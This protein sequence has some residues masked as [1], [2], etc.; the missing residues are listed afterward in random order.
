MAKRFL[1]LVWIGIILLSSSLCAQAPRAFRFQVRLEN[2]AGAPL[3]NR[4]IRM[5]VVIRAGLNGSTV[6]TEQ[7][8]SVSNVFGL[9]NLQIGRGTPSGPAFST[10]NW[11]TGN[12]HIQLRYDSMG[13]GTTFS[14]LGQFPLASIPHAYYAENCQYENGTQAGQIPYWNGTVWIFANAGANLSQLWNCGGILVNTPCAES[15]PVVVTQAVSLI[16]SSSATFSGTISSGGLITQRGFCFATTPSPDLTS[17]V[18]AASPGLGSY[19]APIELLTPS[20][21]YYVRAYAVNGQG[22]QYGQQES[23]VTT[24]SPGAPVVT[25][26]AVQSIRAD[27]ALLSARVSSD[28][29]TRV[30]QR[31]ICW[32]TSPNPSI[33]NKKLILGSDTGNFS[34]FL[35]NLNPGTTY[36]ARAFARNAGGL[37]YSAQVSFTTSTLAIGSRYQG[38][39]VVHF[40]VS[41]DSGFV[42][43][44]VHG[45]IAAP[46]NLFPDSVFL[47]VRDAMYGTEYGFRDNGRAVY[48][49]LVDNP[50][51]P[52]PNV[53]TIGASAWANFYYQQYHSPAHWLR[54]IDSLSTGGYTDWLLPNVTEMQRV[55]AARSHLSNV[56]SDYWY[57]YDHIFDGNQNFR[58]LSNGIMIRRYTPNDD[59]SDNNKK[60]FIRPI[61]YF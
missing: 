34:F 37:T 16:G 57:I 58:Y 13:T 8:S 14:A 22:T 56:M 32:S 23:F 45:V 25:L 27:S 6:Y 26:S 31:G 20:T 12:M 55:W 61:R 30:I 48:V 42:A 29:G 2:A 1:F 46:N 18:V 59:H 50:A 40:F 51:K 5:E 4:S 49:D 17:T 60:C 15:L 43:G 39:T 28:G 7:H 44:E 53:L 36:Y 47:N 38:G 33:T 24:A 19:S 35:S 3:M 10:I 21:Q 54:C 52:N 9:V 41:G 11:S